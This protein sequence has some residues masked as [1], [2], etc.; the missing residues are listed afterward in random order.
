MLVYTTDAL[1]KKRSKCFELVP[2]LTCDDTDVGRVQPMVKNIAWR[3]D[4]FHS[5]PYIDEILMIV[6]AKNGFAQLSIIFFTFK[7]MFNASVM[8]S[9]VDTSTVFVI[10]YFL[11][12][13][14]RRAGAYCFVLSVI[15]S[16]CNSAIL[17]FCPP[18]WNF[19][20]PNNFWT[21][22]ARA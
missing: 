9:F 7:T 19:N 3:A 5:L 10:V 8:Y 13:R 11:C 22:C 2:N 18:L 21:F 6:Y 15:L 20:L 14:D 12:P 1:L 4:A 16:F 17:S